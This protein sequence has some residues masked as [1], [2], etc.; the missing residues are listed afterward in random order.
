[1]KPRL[2][3][4]LTQEDFDIWDRI[5]D[6]YGLKPGVPLWGYIRS[7]R[8][9]ADLMFELVDLRSC[10]AYF[11]VRQLQIMAGQDGCGWVGRVYVWA[12]SPVAL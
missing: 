9:D 7:D 3:A 4:P 2:N 5:A 11:N 6:P 10:G 8:R 12:G 1:M